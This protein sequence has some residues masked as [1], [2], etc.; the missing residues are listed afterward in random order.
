MP[1]ARASSLERRIAAM[2]NPHLDRTP[3]TRRGWVAAAILIGCLSYSVAGVRAGGGGQTAPATLAGTVY[4]PAGGVVPGVSLTLVDAQERTW[5]ARSD[6]G[7]RFEFPA[8]AP[9]SYALEAALPGFRTLKQDLALRVARDWDRAITLQVG[10]VSETVTVSA[11]RVAP[12]P[13]PL[14]PQPSRLKV[15]GNIKAPRKLY[16][17]APVYPQ[18]M[19]EAGREGIVPIEAGIGIDGTVTA[20]RVLSADI[21]PDFAIAAVDAVRQ[22]RFDPTLLNGV[23]VEIRMR[24]SIAF[25][26]SN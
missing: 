5:T 20:V 10:E 7:G 2:L 17:V 11:S 25:K 14:Q 18:G 3:P 12:A 26:L 15:G 1:M 19:R 6:A 24:V 4:D 8:I 23:P 9:G 13:G 22:W 21:H 16:H